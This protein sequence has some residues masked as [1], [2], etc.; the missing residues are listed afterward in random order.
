[1]GGED[2]TFRQRLGYRFSLT[3]TDAGFHDGPL[4][5]LVSRRPSRYGEP[6]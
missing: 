2:L 1:M 5:H 6:I 3:D 4:D